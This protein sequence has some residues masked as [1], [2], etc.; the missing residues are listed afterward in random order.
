MRGWPLVIVCWLAGAPLVAS[1]WPQWRGPALDGSTTETGLPVQWNDGEGETQNV[2]WK[3][4]MA[5]VS[6]STPIITGGRIFLS[7]ALE[8]DLELWVL[9]EQSGRLL[10]KHALGSGNYKR[11]KH[12]MSSPS[13]VTDGKTL[14]VMTGTGRL[15]AFDLASEIFE[16]VWV[17]DLQADYGA[18]GLNHG[19]GASPLLDEGTL[20]VPV[21]HGMKTDDP[22]YVL[23]IDGA[24]GEARWKVERPTDAVRESPDAYTTP[25]IW[26]H[27]DRRD[28]VISGGDYVTGHDLETGKELWRIGGLNPDKAPMYRVVASPVV[29]GNRL[30][31]PSRVKPL[32]ALEAREGQ[33]EVLWALEK[34]TDVPTPVV[35]E[36]VLFVLDDRG[37]VS[38]WEATNGEAIWGPERIAPGTYSASPLLAE[39]RLYMTSEDGVTTVLR[40]GREFE[41]LATNT[42]TGYT[43]SSLAA[44]GGRLYLRTADFLYCLDG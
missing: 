37:L 34:A 19:Y 22:S 33:P 39:G 41:V 15:S 13:P 18:F 24:S 10:S 6:G 31:V 29:A 2:V 26:N 7:V 27:H 43:L 16:E 14:W 3:V 42:A 1:D 8:D 5:G 23:A 32:L 4:P 44:A 21:L 35:A 11:M 28:L 25:M 20:Y 40:A 9:D 38:A 30:Y 17:R 36:G 12:N